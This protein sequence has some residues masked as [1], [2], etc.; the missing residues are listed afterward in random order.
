MSNR[1]RP[2]TVVTSPLRGDGREKVE[3]LVDVVLYDPWIDHRPLRILDG[4]GLLA[5]L[6]ENDAEALIVEAD[7]VYG[8]VFEHPLEF[9]AST[10]GDPNNVDVSAATDAGI[11]VLSTPGRNADAVAELTIGL[12]IATSRHIVAADRATREDRIVD[13]GLI[14]YQRYRG[15]EINGCTVGL[16]GLGA[17]GQAAKWRFEGLGAR[18]IAHDPFNRDAKHS[19]D[20]LLAEA[21]VVSMHAP[22]T[23]DTKGM[24]GPDQFAL[25]KEGAVY[26][27]TARAELHVH[28]ALIEAL[29]SG[30]P[31][32]AGLDHF[33]GEYLSPEDPLAK[34]GNVV[35][36]PH[37][38]GA[39]YDTER[40]QTSMIADDLERLLSGERPEHIVNP[41]VLGDG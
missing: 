38:G 36:T 18:V 22:S 11:P 33:E 6:E 28:E 3:K 10:R 40:R 29:R 19:L 41:Q 24:I 2:R 31:A 16:V 23:P 7:F 8:A 32:A 34:M 35:L 25:M 13:D 4:D 12:L 26:L 17:V 1:T 14:P 39:T 5:L 30:K 15:W 21:D 27:N 37:I 20:D 9:I